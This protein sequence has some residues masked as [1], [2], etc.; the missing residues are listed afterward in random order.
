M[1]ALPFLTKPSIVKP[2]FAGKLNVLVWPDT[3]CILKPLVLFHPPD[4]A[5]FEL[6]PPGQRLSPISVISL[7]LLPSSTIS[8]IPNSPTAELPVKSVKLSS[9]SQ[10]STRSESVTLTTVP[11]YSDEF[12]STLVSVPI[13][14]SLSN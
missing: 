7:P 2:V 10:S 4:L 13:P 11:T 14:E 8:K 5:A 3:V 9:K 12:L 1:L 6:A